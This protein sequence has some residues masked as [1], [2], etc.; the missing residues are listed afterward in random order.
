MRKFGLQYLGKSFNMPSSDQYSEIKV[1]LK[2]F[3]DGYTKRN[4]EN[5]D[6]FVDELF[7]TG[8][9]TI[10]LGTGTGELLLGSSQVKTLI[11][12]DWQYWG[13]V[14]ISW[15]NAYVDSQGDAAWFASAGTLK[16][17]FEDKPERYDSYINFIKSKAMDAGLSPKQKITFI[18]WVLSLTYHQRKDS[19]REYLW[20]LNLSGVLLKENDNWKIS[21]LHFSIPGADFPDERFEN[22]PEHMEN[23]K[24]QNDKALQYKNN[25]MT[26]ELKM[27]LENL[28]TNFF[29][30]KSVSAKS[31]QK[32]FTADS[33]PYIIGPENQ[34]YM[35]ITQ[36]KDY[37]NENSI[38]ALS[39][40][41]EHAIASKLKDITWVTVTGMLK[42][43]L[44]EEELN[45]RALEDLNNLLKSDLSSK[46]KLFEAHRS[47]A[48]VLKESASGIHYT[49]PVRLTAVIGNENTRPVFKYIH[50]SFPCYWIFEG[51]IN[52]TQGE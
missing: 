41:I 14:N 44:T 22:S 30:Q 52:S 8:D 51:K 43:D 16:Y 31:V 39:L 2:K 10:V 45:F 38:L 18:N 23:Y 21:H 37:F 1:V 11:S 35:G 13:D 33:L 50:F 24:K 48:Y 25:K 20:P 49:F 3:Q 29:G 42:Q 27:L 34:Y 28:E 9:D 7:I 26:S 5:A 4:I 12:D 17:V 19:I 40:D 46:E 15:E 6:A 32:L 47:I 36:V